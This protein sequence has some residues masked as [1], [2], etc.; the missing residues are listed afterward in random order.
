MLARLSR[1]IRSLG[2]ADQSVRSDGGVAT[3]G[4]RTVTTD[5]LDFDLAQLTDGVGTP[6]FALD[7]DGRVAVWNS[8]IEELTGV[9]ADEALGMEHVS[10]A[11]YPDGRRAQTLAD[12]VLAHPETADREF[13]LERM[14]ADRRLYT[15][16]SVMVDR[17]G[18]ERHIR[19]N[20]M[21]LYD[22][23]DLAGVVEVVHDRTETVQQSQQTQALVDELGR[24][25]GSV[26][27]GNLGR[28]ASPVRPATST[29][30]DSTRGSRNW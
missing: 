28:L 5:A 4:M 3:V 27:D 30:S 21:P 7:A 17:H 14:D 2:G 9:P 11:F 22:G 23:E 10:E 16:Q 1:W 26:A 12:K 19:F 13:G 25:I 8:A 29:T 18:T 24:T 20:A 6:L 15:D